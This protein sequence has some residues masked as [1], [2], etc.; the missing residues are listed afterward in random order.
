[1]MIHDFALATISAQG[2][3]YATPMRTKPEDIA[4]CGNQFEIEKWLLGATPDEICSFL[5]HTSK[6]SHDF[7]FAKVALNIRIA[8][9]AEKT[10]RRLLWLTV[11]VAILTAAILVIEF[12][13]MAA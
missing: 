3:F 2:Q 5:T 8:N 11:I 9:S 12:C 7:E 13:D 1:M 6:D 10:N 4:K